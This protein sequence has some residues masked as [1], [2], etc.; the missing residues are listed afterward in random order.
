[1]AECDVLEWSVSSESEQFDPGRHSRDSELRVGAPVRVGRLQDLRTVRAEL[2]RLYREAR[3]REG[4]YPDA[5]T[6]QRLANVLGSLRTAIE[7]EDLEKRLC[8]LEE[9]T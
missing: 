6:A 3:R 9:K 8:K 7:L 5:L 2:G 4:R 1:L